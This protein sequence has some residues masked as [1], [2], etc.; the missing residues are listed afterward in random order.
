MLGPRDREN[1]MRETTAYRASSISSHM[2]GIPGH[3]EKECDF[4]MRND[5]IQHWDPTGGHGT[6]R[7]AT[8]PHGRPRDP[9]G[10]HGTPR[11]A[12]GPHAGTRFFGY[13]PQLIHYQHRQDPYRASSVWEIYSYIKHIFLIFLHIIVFFLIVFQ[14]L[15]FEILVLIDAEATNFFFRPRATHYASFPSHNSRIT[16]YFEHFEV[17][18]FFRYGSNI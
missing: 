5:E 2:V 8:G 10:G 3:C 13:P 9:T 18:V 17:S 7:E 11:E 12:T 1:P 14:V 15:T 6:P 16:T 4:K